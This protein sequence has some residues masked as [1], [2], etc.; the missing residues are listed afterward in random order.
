M[1]QLYQVPVWETEDA[2]WDDFPWWKQRAITEEAYAEKDFRECT[3]HQWHL[4]VDFGSVSVDCANCHADYELY[5]GDPDYVQ[6]MNGTLPIG[7]ISYHV[8]K[9]GLGEFVDQWLEFS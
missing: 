8:E 2:A 4:N 6:S 5:C 9:S 1:F 7:D 3:G